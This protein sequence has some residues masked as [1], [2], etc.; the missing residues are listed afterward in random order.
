MPAG[1]STRAGPGQRPDR[2]AC[3]PWSDRQRC[4]RPNQGIRSLGMARL[5]AGRR[6][7][8]GTS[9]A[10]ERRRAIGG[11]R[12]DVPIRR[13]PVPALT[14]NGPKLAGLGPGTRQDRPGSGHA[15]PGPVPHA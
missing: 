11:P 12:A 3:S 15:G 9:A 7:K 6:A 13:N 4:G 10:G 2:P 1:P 5:A 14:R 8:S